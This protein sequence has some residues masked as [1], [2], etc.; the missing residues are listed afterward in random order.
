MSLAVAAGGPDSER[1][2]SLPACGE[3]GAPPS[4]DSRLP[5]TGVP[6]APSRRCSSSGVWGRVG[7]SWSSTNTQSFAMSVMKCRFSWARSTRKNRSAVQAAKRGTGKI[8]AGTERQ[9]TDRRWRHKVNLIEHGQH[10][11]DGTVTA[12]REYTQLWYFAE[13]LKPVTGEK[14]NSI[15]FV[16]ITRET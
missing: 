2:S 9:H 12:A 4:P 7:L 10:P 13:Q 11:A 6:W 1:S 14:K 3:Q 15:N 8:V 16:L 5:A